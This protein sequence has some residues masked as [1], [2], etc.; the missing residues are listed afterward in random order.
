MSRIPVLFLISNPVD[1]DTFNQS[2]R[3]QQYHFFSLAA[4]D[5][6]GDHSSSR[7]PQTLESVLTRTIEEVGAQ[8]LLAHLGLAFDRHPVEFLS[9]V[10]DAHALHPRLK[11]GLDKGVHYALQSLQMSTAPGPEAASLAARLVR[12]RSAFHMDEETTALAACLH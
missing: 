8:Y 5:Y 3:F 6:L 11:V 2:P 12:H 9:A 10:L 7:R 1:L 4:M